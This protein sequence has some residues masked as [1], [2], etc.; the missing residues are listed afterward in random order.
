MNAPKFIKESE[1]SSVP[2]TVW[3]VSSWCDTDPACF[4]GD[5]EEVFED[6]RKEMSLTD[7]NHT[8]DTMVEYLKVS[9]K[10]H[11]NI[12][13]TIP[14]EMR[15]KLFFHALFDLKVARPFYEA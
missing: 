7:L 6:L 15:R 2:K 5:P 12:P 11:I 14:E 4:R 9:R 13:K 8:L 3:F 1:L 10:M